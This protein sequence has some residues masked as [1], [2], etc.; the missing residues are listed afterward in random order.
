[1]KFDDMNNEIKT[2][3]NESKFISNK[4]RN[5]IIKMLGEEFKCSFDREDYVD[6]ANVDVTILEAKKILLRDKEYSIEN[7][8]DDD[9]LDSFSHFKEKADGYLSTMKFDFDS[10]NQF[11]NIVNLLIITFL[12]VIAVILL[13]VTIN[14]LRK[15]NYFFS[16]WIAIFVLPTLIPKLKE[17]ILGRLD[18][19]K[20]YIKKL[21]RKK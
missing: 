11:N 15:G 12:V 10:K 3:L 21:F 2:Y 18:Q 9:I 4:C 19:A 16:I 5:R 20:R 14:D 7:L 17:N 1:M 13:F 6:F 8:T